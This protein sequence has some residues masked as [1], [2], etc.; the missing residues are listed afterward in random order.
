MFATTHILASIVISQ[1]IPSPGWAFLISLLSHFLLDL[2]PH[3]DA[4]LGPWMAADPKKRRMALVLGAD[5]FCSILFL[6]FFWQNGNLPN[7]S[8]LIP[9]MIGGVLPDFIWLM[10]YLFK[11]CEFLK[12]KCLFFT[13]T[14]HRI[15][16]FHLHAIHT[17]F[18]RKIKKIWVGI[19]I[20]TIFFCGLVYCI[21]SWR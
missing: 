11:G 2:I 20:Q 5:A 15:N 12:T 8:S 6:V 7:L 19:V 18:D 16:S 17:F 14:L 1:H 3:G 10:S 13:A 4:P 9:A 21:A